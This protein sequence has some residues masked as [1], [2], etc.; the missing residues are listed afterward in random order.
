MACAYIKSNNMNPTPKYDSQQIVVLEGLEPVRKRPAMY[1]GSTD[2][3]GLH[4]CLTELVDNAIDEALA[5]FAKNIWVIIH[6]DNSATVA[7]DGRGFPIDIMPKYKKPAVEVVMTTLH[8]GGKFGGAAYKVSGGLHG[9]GAACVNA[10][11]NLYQIEVRKDNQIY[12]IEFTRGVTKTKLTQISETKIDR[13]KNILPKNISGTTATFYPDPEIF[14]ETIELDSKTVIKSLKDRAYLTS[15]IYFHFYDERNNSQHHYYFEGGIISLL[16]EQNKNKVVLHEPIYLHR[17]EQDIDAEIAIQYNDSFNENTPSFVNIINTSEGGTH[18]TGF[19][20]ALTKVIKDYAT[21]KELL[22]SKD[23]TIT[24]DDVK[25]GLTAVLSIKMPS[26]DLQFEGQTKSKLG[27]SE[28]QPIMA[29]IVREELEIY[30]EEHPDIAKIIVC[31]SI[32]AIQIRKAA[33]AAKDAIMRKGAFDSLGLPGKL[34]DC[35]SKNPAECEIYIVEGDSAGGCFSANTKIALTDG[36]NVTFKQLVNEDKHGKENFCY[37]VNSEGNICIS[38]IKNPRIT[39]K[40]TKVIKIILDNDEKIICTP[41][42]PFMLRNGLYKKAQELT[43]N[44]SLMP[45]KKQLSR[46]GKRITIKGYEMVYNPG[47]HRW[48]FTHM[49]ADEYNIQKGIYNK[50]N[51]D[52]RHHIDFNKLNNNP[53]NLTR[54]TKGE[55]MDLHKDILAKTIH[56]K[57]IKEKTAKLHQTPQYRQ[58][59]SQIMSTP[60]MHYL[61]SER[62]K[63]QWQNEDYKKYMVQKFLEFYGKNKEYQKKNKQLLNDLQKQYWSSDENKQKQAERTTQYYINHPEQ[64]LILKNISIKQWSD[65]SL[66]QWRSQETQKQWTPEFRNQRK[67]TYNKT[68]LNKALS[69]LHQIYLN[70]KVID[71]SQY[72]NLRKS[73]RDKSLLR[74]ETICQRFFENNDKV[75]QE[76]ILNYNHRIKKIIFLKKQIDVYDLEIPK[77]H[78]FALSSG[79]FVH[80]SAKQGRDRKFQAILPLWGKA[81]NTEGMRLDKIVGS[82]KLKDFIIALGMGIGETFNL[83]K[84][85]YHRIILMADADVDGAHISTLLLTFLFRHLPGVIENGYVYIAMPPLYKIKQGKEVKYVYTDEEKENYLKKID[86]SKTFDIQRYKGL[87]EMNPTQLWETTMNPETRILKKVNIADAQRADEIFRILMG[88]D[89]P[90][91]KKFIQTHA[92]LAT[93]D[94]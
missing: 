32:L 70:S 33:R 60:K 51:G 6:P 12:F 11:S 93:L 8:S 28:V 65:P 38:K 67:I 59:I 69:A 53:N 77:H 63:K 45:F 92:H 76:A 91:R 48:I 37:S 66:R 72:L 54:L 23:D 78:N 50:N 68:Y 49:L 10:L 2:I 79:I 64:K 61:L 14:K 15:K 71:K 4:H 31:K 58:M 57:D 74:Y 29:K 75:F 43:P 40:N 84:L 3:R 19:K 94:I 88:E 27:N 18:L 30:F 62:A 9:V 39:K 41:D 82:D 5:G 87:G 22:K 44:D 13:L 26:K 25:E 1:I 47:E 86:T 42:H 55:H 24:G 20:S 46:I 17:T 7:D 21:K 90:P 16:K 83:E 89:V 35:Q 34:A 80:N 81:L 36:R 85:R 73:T 52:H 56:R